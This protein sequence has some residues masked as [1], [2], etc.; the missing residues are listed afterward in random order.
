VVGRL[1]SGVYLN[2]EIWLGKRF[3]KPMLDEEKAEVG[4]GLKSLF[5]GDETLYFFI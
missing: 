1:W 3:S 2:Y 5:V 4:R